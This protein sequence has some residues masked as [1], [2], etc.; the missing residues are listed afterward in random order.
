MELSFSF[1]FSDMSF[2]TTQLNSIIQ[3]NCWHLCVVLTHILVV[4]KGLCFFSKNLTVIFVGLR[5]YQLVFFQK[6]ISLSGISSW[7]EFNLG[8]IDV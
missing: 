6:I 1:L 4:L 3:K 5:S 2:T 7:Q 8:T